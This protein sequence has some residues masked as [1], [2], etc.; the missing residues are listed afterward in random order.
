M[1]TCAK[2]LFDVG[3]SVLCRALSVLRAL[4]GCFC[5]FLLTTCFTVP[6]VALQRVVELPVIIPNG[7]RTG[8]GV[9]ADV[10]LSSIRLGSLT[11]D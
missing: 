3:T 7:L 6:I 4:A 2:I 11:R 5:C 9:A 8:Q 1:T 10:G